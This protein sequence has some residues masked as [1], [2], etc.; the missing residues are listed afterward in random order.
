MSL[1]AG[2]AEH[3]GT[4]SGHD[5]V[6][7]DADADPLPARLDSFLQRLRCTSQAIQ[8]GPWR[9]NYGFLKKK[10]GPKDGRHS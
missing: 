9:L 6:V 1:A 8:N 5:H 10:I 7:F 2:G 3:L 4:L